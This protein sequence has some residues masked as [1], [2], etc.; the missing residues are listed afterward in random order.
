MNRLAACII[1][2]N[3]EK[4]LPRALASLAGVA[5]EII[6]VDAG[7]TDRSCD[8]AR[9]AGARLFHRDW[10]NY[11]E[12]KNFAADQSSCEWVFSIDADE[13]LSPELGNNLLAWKQAD[14]VHMAY[15]VSRRAHYLGGWVRHSGWY[16]DRQMRLY[17]RDKARFSGIVHESVNVDGTI[18]LLR[19]DLLHYPADT[20]GE[21]ALK[22]DVY[23]TLAAKQLCQG[24]RR[25]WRMAMLFAPPWTFFQ[26]F[27]LCA[28]FLD[29]Y[30]GWVIA[31]GAARYV[32]LKYRKLGMVLEAKSNQTRGLR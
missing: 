26:K 15:S 1:T 11:S 28:G 18:G 20:V 27:V 23:T 21:N 31:R 29:G 7:S 13:E 14:P 25:S 2:L 8:I 16:P 5:D 19:G 9:N 17:R 3:E 22:L 30:R 12:Q 4:N 32:R 24:N 6:V 10:T